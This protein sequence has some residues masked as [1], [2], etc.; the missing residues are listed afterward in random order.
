MGQEPLHRKISEY[1]DEAKAARFEELESMGYMNLTKEEGSEHAG[2]MF[3]IVDK[4]E[5][6]GEF[7]TPF[8][9]HCRR[10]GREFDNPVP[11][12]SNPSGIR[13]DIA[14]TEW[15]SDFNKTAM[16][17]LYRDSGAYY[18]YGLRPPWQGEGESKTPEGGSKHAG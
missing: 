17:A 5:T 15:C 9:G 14:S 12:V 11:E 13:T 7:T 2:L 8:D 18:V 1:L 4:K 6:L 10:C 16:S 3:E